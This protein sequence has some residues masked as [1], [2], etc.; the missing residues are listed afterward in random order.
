MKKVTM[1]VMVVLMSL[2]GLFANG[3]CE[4]YAPL[5]P[6][7]ESVPVKIGECRRMLYG[8]CDLAENR[9]EC[10]EKIHYSENANDL[11]AYLSR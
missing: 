11:F 1:F 10:I 3:M 2:T 5:M 9:E 8:N 6:G 4:V 7:E